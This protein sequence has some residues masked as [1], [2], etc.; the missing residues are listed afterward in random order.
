M[1]EG[2][3]DFLRSISSKTEPTLAETEKKFFEKHRSSS[4]DRPERNRKSRRFVTSPLSSATNG[5]GMRLG[6]DA[7]LIAQSVA[8][9]YA[10]G[11]QPY[12]ENATLSLPGIPLRIANREAAEST[13]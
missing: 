8:W 7:L 13:S 5:G 11:V 10:P 2:I 3:V 4:L 1:S 12:L 6:A 9:A